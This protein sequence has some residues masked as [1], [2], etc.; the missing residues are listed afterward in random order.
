MQYKDMEVWKQSMEL[1]FKIYSMT[2]NFPKNEIFG[3]TSQMRRC[4]ISIPSNIAE[5]SNRYSDK[6]TLRFIYIAQ[7]SL[8]ELET[9]ILISQRLGYINDLNEI[10]E[11]VSKISALLTGLR[12][13][14]EK[15]DI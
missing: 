4:A 9:Q 15:K 7:G 5:G 8:A 12:K 10:N 3:L 13:Y 6:E 14:F 1:C 2:D 11:Q